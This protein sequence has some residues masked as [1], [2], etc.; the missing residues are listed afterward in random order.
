MFA[1]IPERFVSR[2]LRGDRATSEG[3]ASA[4][5]EGVA[6]HDRTRRHPGRNAYRVL[7]AV[8]DPR[9]PRALEAGGFGRLLASPPANA[10][11]AAASRAIATR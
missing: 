8:R 7:R 1:R 4:S 10:A 6:A 2:N 11:C 3:Y 9:L 5:A